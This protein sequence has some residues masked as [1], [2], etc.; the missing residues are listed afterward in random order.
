V[1]AAAGLFGC[2]NGFTCAALA[3]GTAWCWGAGSEGELGNGTTAFS[4]GAVQVKDLT[5]V[6]GI[7]SGQGENCALLR[8]GMVRCW[9]SNA[10]G[11]LGDGKTEVQSSTPVAVA[12]VSGAKQIDADEAVTMVLL[13]DG[14]AAVWPE[15]QLA[16]V[17]GLTG[18][19]KVSAGGCAIVGT[20]V[21][22]WMDGPTPTP[23]PGLP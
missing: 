16:T 21:V 15:P 7:S 6:V 9:G 19:T 8:D 3:D 4:S 10:S 1:Q 22:C 11:A 5:T 13:A 2:G 17:P 23:V 12:G 18:A 14:S 20:G